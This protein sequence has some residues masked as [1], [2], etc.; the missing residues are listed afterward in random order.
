M[1]ATPVRMELREP[2]LGLE[3]VLH[4]EPSQCIV[5]VFRGWEL[6]C[7]TAQMSLLER[8]YYCVQE[9]RVVDKR[10]LDDTPLCA[11]PVL[12]ECDETCGSNRP[13]IIGGEGRY[14]HQIAIYRRVRAGDNAPLC[15]VPVLDQGVGAMA[16]KV[17]VIPHSPD[18]VR[19]DGGHPFQG[20]CIK[21]WTMTGGNAPLCAIP[22]LNQCEGIAIAHSPDIIGGVGC[23]C[24]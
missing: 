19:G 9:I 20:I 6:S 7:P 12:G 10:A 13:N 24:D 3:T 17:R 16:A 8:A 5:S 11:I 1:A 4:V 22:V 14:P 2:A 15:A 18:V 23:Y 21:P